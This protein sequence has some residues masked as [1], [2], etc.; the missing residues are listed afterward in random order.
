MKLRSLRVAFPA[1][2]A[3]VIAAAFSTHP[4]VAQTATPPASINDAGPDSQTGIER[5]ATGVALAIPG[6]TL[7]IEP[8]NE[9]IV[10][11]RF[12]RTLDWPGSYNPAVTGRVSDVAWN[13]ATTPEAITV[14]TATLKV[15]V[16]RSNGAIEFLDADGKTITTATGLG[17]SSLPADANGAVKQLFALDENEAAYGLGQHQGGLMDYRGNTV[18]LQQANR[19]VAVPMFVSSRGYGILWNNASVTNVDVSLPQAS[20]QL[21]FRSE[22]GSGID[23]DFIY[24][25]ELDG[26]VGGYRALTGQA[27][28]MARWTWGLWQSKERYQSQDELVGV[29]RRYR[30][31]G[32]PLDAVVQD[33]QYWRKDG[34]GSHEFDS[35]RYPDP[36]AMMRELH[37]ANVHAIISVWARFNLGTANLAALDRAGAAYP[38][39]YQSDYPFGPARWYD[40]F[41]KPG[42]ALYW[43][44]IMAHLGAQGF[45]GW[46][47]DASEPE[48]GGDPDQMRALDTAQGPGTQ[49]YNAYPLWHTTGVY[50][51][52]RRDLPNKR[53]FILTRSAF[54]GQQRNAAVTW[55]GD[56]H[57]TWDALRR[58]IPAGLNF[59]LS[60][61]PYWSADIGGFFGGSPQDPAYAELFTR[62]YQFAVFNPMF[63]VHGT[64][65]GREPW[66]FPE[67]TQKILV[68]YDRLRYRLL[69]YI[70]SLSWDVTHRS[71]TMMRPLAMDFRGDPAALVIADEYMF[72]KS[73]LVS[74]VVQAAAAIRTVYLPAGSAW[75]DF[76]TG[77]RQEG[78]Q[79]VGAKADIS[80]IPLY[81]PA[82]S[83][84]PL[85]PVKQ[86]ADQRSDA[87]IELRIYP[88]KDGAFE[89][90]DD[91]GDGHGYEAARYSTLSLAW[92]DNEHRLQFGS[93]VGSFPGQ[94][95][96][97][98]F[99]LVCGVQGTHA[100]PVDMVYAG[101]ALTVPLPDCHQ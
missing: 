46:W 73:L 93:R 21:V 3:L 18:R 51:G 75:Y 44:Q 30:A 98:K 60:G 31:L 70:Y 59:S 38:P 50:E 87:A 66:A 32:I 15:R 19:D 84:L 69:P 95:S 61:I 4:A 47:L 48:L 57:G 52:A 22:Y 28:M 83:I 25:P 85:G 16:K 82:G 10:H 24:G 33:W 53:P 12:G 74:P 68:Q 94:A 40:P 41:S 90:Y 55:S 45:D 8:W 64:G 14:S 29:A 77:Q 6:A 96:R 80:T 11:V 17:P 5:T 37:A 23:Y 97:Q 58:Q 13:L 92:K 79:V 62:W 26:V 1:F 36:A 54:A 39:V 88:G 63:R 72:G 67:A 76:W 2:T 89:L 91:E 81:V 34:W 20:G 86:Y 99:R 100:K 7:R 35:T 49:V 56:T 9:R 43:Q 42:R 101:D 65:G 78:G 71:G 27:P